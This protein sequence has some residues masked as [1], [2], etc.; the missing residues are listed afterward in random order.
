[1]LAVAFGNKLC[2]FESHY[3]HISLWSPDS[4]T[5]ASSSLR[6]KQCWFE[7]HSR[8]TSLC[9]PDIW[10]CA[11]S[12]L[13]KKNYVVSSPT[14]GTPLYAPQTVENVLTVAFGNKLCWFESHYRYIFL[15]SPGSWTRAS[16]SLRSTQLTIYRHPCPRWDSKRQSQQARGRRPSIGIFLYVSVRLKVSLMGKFE[17]AIVMVVLRTQGCFG[18]VLFQ[19]WGARVN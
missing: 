5:R 14:I 11:S 9:S 17:R 1:M 2:W 7:F 10:T 19:G 4:W 15:C 8:H 3:R 16:S 13:G 12:S 6:K 18:I